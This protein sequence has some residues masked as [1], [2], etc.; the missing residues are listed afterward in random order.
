M[1]ILIERIKNAV[2]QFIHSLQWKI[3]YLRERLEGVL[4]IYRV[5]TQH[6]Y[7][8]EENNLIEKSV[9]LVQQFFPKPPG[10]TLLQEDFESRCEVIEDFAHRLIEIYGMENVEVIITD[11]PE[12][13]P[14]DGGIV[15]G[16]TRMDQRAV[17]INAN[18]LQMDNEDVLAHLVGT[19]IHELRHVMQYEIMTLINTRGV[20]YQ[21]RKAWRYTTI[22]YVDSG[23]DMEAYSKQSIEFDAR[24]FTNRV[25]Q[26]AYGQNIPLGGH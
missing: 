7:S 18:L 21:R 14:T 26:G 11:D 13:F 23:H 6:I 9:G 3:E 16:M 1:A 19:V 24:N 25:W 10:P 5:D 20:P 15:F 8:H 2:N 12:V 4:G 22:N 17:Y